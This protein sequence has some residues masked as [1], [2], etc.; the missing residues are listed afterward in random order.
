MHSD[1]IADVLTRIRN[2]QSVKHPKVQVKVSKIVTRLLE[3]L[4]TEGFI[5][6]FKLN[7]EVKHGVYE[8][9]L[10]YYPN[11]EA[12]IQNAKRVSKPGC[13]VYSGSS[14]LPK[15]KSG[16]GIAIVSTS[17]G[18]LTDFEAR[19]RKIGGEVIALIS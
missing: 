12:V 15:V 7:T 4:Q 5:K 3:V 14:D 19:K 9:E 6:S 11:G 8:V 16:L 1:P 18:V 2:A 10:K 17:E 13:R